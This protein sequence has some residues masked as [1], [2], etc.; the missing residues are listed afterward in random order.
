LIAL[1]VWLATFYS[2]RYVSLASILAA[3][4]IPVA[5]Y[6]LNEPRLV[7]GLAVLIS[8]FV[9]VLHRAN[10]K[11]LLNGTESRFSKKAAAVPPVQS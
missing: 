10:I 5:A 11:R 4:A 8:A 3:V 2:S 7:L 1:A 9:I 6:F